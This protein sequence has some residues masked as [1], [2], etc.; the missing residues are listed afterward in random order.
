LCLEWAA[1]LLGRTGE[2]LRAAT[3]FG[4][5]EAVWRTSGTT[6]HPLRE[7]P[8][9]RDVQAVQ[10]QLEQQAFADAWA[11]GQAMTAPQA[12]AYALGET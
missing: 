1:A 12:I 3:L 6:R 8:H 9:E 10:S 2:P 5:A 11:H 7:L 4:A